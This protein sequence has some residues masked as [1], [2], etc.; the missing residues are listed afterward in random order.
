MKTNV[1]FL[2]IFLIAHNFLATISYAGATPV[3][4]DNGVITGRILEESTNSP[5]EY[6][7]VAVYRKSDST[8][9]TGT[10]T[11]T[12]GYFNLKK[13]QPGE[14][15]VNIS[16]LGFEKK[17]ISSIVIKVSNTTNDLGVI[18]LSPESSQISE[19]SVVGEKSK[20]EYKIDK[21]VINADKYLTSQ[22]G[23]AVNVLENT[24]SVQ[25][26][27]Q[28]NIT[29]RG[30]SDYIVLIN[31]KPT[32]TKGSDALKQIPASSIKQIEVITN[33]SARFD[34]EGQSGIINVILKKDRLQGLNGSLNASG[35]TRD[36]YNGNL[37][38]NYKKGKV[39]YFTGIDYADNIYRQNIKLDNRIFEQ[40]S[41]IFFKEELNAYS[42]NDNM[43]VKGGVDIDFNDK[44]SMT[45]AGSIGIQGYDNGTDANLSRGVIES[46]TANYQSS[47][48]H[49]DVEGLVAQFNADYLYKFTDNQTL[50]FTNHYSSWDGI[51]ENNLSVFNTSPTFEIESTESKINYN[52][53]NFN[54]EYRANIDYKQPVGSGNLEAGYQFRF[55][56]RYNEL[57]FSNLDIP[58]NNWIKNDVFSY[59]HDYL[60]YINSGYLTYSNKIY[61][62]GYQLG[63]RSEYFQRE[64]HITNEADDFNFDKFMVYP[65][66]HFSKDFNG[67]HQLQLSYSRRINRPQSYV[68][69][70]TP[71]Y[72]DP[73]NIQ[74]GSPEL[75]PEY[76]DAYE[77]NYRNTFGRVTL[78]V[79]N[80]YRHTTNCLT[81]IRYQ[82]EDG[83]MYH[84]LANVNTQESYG[85]ESGLDINLFTW[86][87]VSAL[88]NL[89]LYN[90]NSNV[91]DSEVEKESLTWDARLISSLNFKTGTRIQ[92]IGY[93]RAAGVDA[94]GTTTN[95]YVVNLA[96]NQ[97]L[98]N[99]KLNF[100]I[101]AQNIFN[102]IDFTYKVEESNGKW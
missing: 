92:A 19:V 29:L 63:L 3:E 98:M 56:N 80:Y 5:M 99:G 66:V 50:S 64:I 27:P 87:H 53:D 34:A 78:S 35:G 8:L 9:V 15:F 46:N 90:I 30:S 94:A 62:I 72:L 57:V 25:V 42:N 18:H 13:I 88:A 67:K 31:G 69:H 1:L 86:W 91:Q 73:Y 85:I 43:A 60:N 6:V 81:T 36:K 20:I 55:E 76:T 41:T 7:N 40:S 2:F 101:S 65:S 24:P 17:T 58:T 37:L 97:S 102:S 21:R 84:Q 28:G 14:Y 59:T 4:P 83:I 11:D 51:D 10:I 71:V 70:N 95:F 96:A 32:V 45:L 39:N 52:R 74:L 54:F 44:N 100:G 89:Y 77:F 93:Y 82:K 26:D 75:E 12:D 68:L 48:N 38:L 79:Q 47:F 23:T 33:P 16:F 22:G 49:M 61:T